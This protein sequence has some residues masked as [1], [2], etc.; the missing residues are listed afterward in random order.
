MDW[1]ALT[2]QMVYTGRELVVEIDD[3]DIGGARGWDWIKKGIPVRVEIGPRDMAED[4]VFVG[5]RRSRPTT[6]NLHAQAA[7]CPAGQYDPGRHPVGSSVPAGLNNTGKRT[8]AIDDRSDF[9][10]F[11]TPLN[12]AE[13]PEIHGGF[14][15]SHWC[16]SAV[17][18][19]AERRPQRRPSA[20]CP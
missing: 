17:R 14:A 11:F 1:P 3:R 8:P 19:Q 12:N 13:K 16:G 6:T 20:A 2:G 15:M 10:T 9:Y 4:A 7:V 5:R 18:S